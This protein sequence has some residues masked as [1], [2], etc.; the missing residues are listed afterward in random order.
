MRTAPDAFQTAV[1]EVIQDGTPM[2]DARALHGWLG[3]KDPFHKWVKRRVV[4]YG[5]EEG[6]DFCTGLFKTGG[7]PRTDYLLTRDMAKELA[8]VERTEVGRATRRYFI[9]ME[10]AASGHAGDIGRLAPH[11]KLTYPASS[12][13]LR[14]SEEEK[15]QSARRASLSAETN[16]QTLSFDTSLKPRNIFRRLP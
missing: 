15:P 7:R 1:P 13:L 10:G 3:V 9:L 4:E 2:F 6:P 16:G 8:M 5:F 14:V 12:Q 11:S